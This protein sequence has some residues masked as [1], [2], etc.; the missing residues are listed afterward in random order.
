MTNHKNKNN[1]ILNHL[2][3][4]SVSDIAKGIMIDYTTSNTVFENCDIIDA[5]ILHFLST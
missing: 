3:K 5:Y 2:L 1:E 4:N